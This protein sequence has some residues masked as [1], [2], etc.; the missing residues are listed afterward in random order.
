MACRRSSGPPARWWRRRRSSRQAVLRGQ[1]PAAR[2]GDTPYLV[3]G[4]FPVIGAAAA[5]A[6]DNGRSAPVISAP[7]VSSRKVRSSLEPSRQRACLFHARCNGV[8]D[9]CYVN[10]SCY[11]QVRSH[12]TQ[13]PGA[14]GL[15]AHRRTAVPPR[16]TRRQRPPA[17]GAA[18]APLVTGLPDFTALVEH[19]G[20]AVVNVQ[21][22]EAPRRRRRPR[23]P[24][25]RGS[26]RSVQRILPS[27]RHSQSRMRPGRPA[28]QCAAGARRGFRLHRH[29]ATATS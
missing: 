22:T 19:Y 16:C 15:L 3:A 13:R 23:G 6:G 24:A 28:R 18:A 12:C 1:H 26:Q 7:P 8:E 29:D 20:P 11:L 14:V 25:G 21:V 4:N 27:L 2:S 10:G 5:P 17:V 9:V